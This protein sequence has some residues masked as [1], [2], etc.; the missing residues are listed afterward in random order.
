MLRK[1]FEPRNQP[2]GIGSVVETRRGTGIII[3]HGQNVCLVRFKKT[4]LFLKGG[5]IHTNAMP[6]GHTMTIP[7]SQLKE[8]GMA[9]IRAGEKLIKVH[10]Y[11]A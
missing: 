4:E 11:Q 1:A 7:T 10:R 8:Y 9:R 5:I 2:K 6:D 3:E